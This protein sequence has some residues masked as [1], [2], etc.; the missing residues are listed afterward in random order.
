[1][2]TCFGPGAAVK[3][4]CCVDA[5]EPESHR[6][7]KIPR[8]LMAQVLAVAAVTAVVAAVVEEGGNCQL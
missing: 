5:E 2:S 6:G 4:Q 7:G 8:Q 3:G 1:V